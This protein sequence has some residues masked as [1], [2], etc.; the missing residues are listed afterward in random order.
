MFEL[1]IKA[2][3]SYLLG[4]VIGS[5]VVGRFMGGTDIRSEGS[6][7]P[8][9][10]NAFRTRGWKFALPVV[11][12]DAGKGLV[13]VLLIAPLSLPFVAP[14]MG[15]P[16][17]LAVSCGA[18]AVIGHVWPVWFGFRGGKGMATYVGVLAGLGWPLLAVALLLWVVVLILTGFVSVATMLA[19][20]GV[21]LYTLLIGAVG[22][23]FA[24]AAV[25]AAFMIYT[26]RSNIVRL[27]DGTEHRFEK[28]ML[29]S[30]W[31]GA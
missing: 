10:T 17:W 13:A 30:R 26:H 4:A 15:N 3:L 18:A 21:A 14:F 12:I 5:L 9:G 31:L 29:L 6:G 20:I 25:M 19:A 7:N 16:G 1:L 2:L 24:F 23:L 27:R 8:G 22:P 11:L 28:V